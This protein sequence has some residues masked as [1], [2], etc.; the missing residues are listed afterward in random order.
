MVYAYQEDFPKVLQVLKQAWPIF[1]ELG[2]SRGQVFVLNN[3]AM[4]H[5]QSGDYEQALEY[6][7]K[8]LQL[9]VVY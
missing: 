2:N 8:G 6:G 4:V 7:Q 5:Y 9:A 1:K 3:I